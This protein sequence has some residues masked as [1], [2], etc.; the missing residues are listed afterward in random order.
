MRFFLTLI[1]LLISYGSLYPFDFQFNAHSGEAFIDMLW[2][3][4]IKHHSFS[5]NLGNIALFLPFGVLLAVKKQ[6][7]PTSSIPLWLVLGLTLAAALQIFQLFIPSRDPS[8]RDVV[9][10]TA[11]MLAGF[12]VGK[13]GF[14]NHYLQKTSQPAITLEWLLIGSWLSYQLLPFVPTMD[15]GL[16]WDNLKKLRSPYINFR[17]AHS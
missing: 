17:S 5:D 8:L 14:G 9:W 4:T 6:I 15:I 2:T 1:I 13:L 16:I 12:F 11:G 10:N 3:G 7:E